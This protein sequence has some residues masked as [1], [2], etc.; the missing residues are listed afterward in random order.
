MLTL[1]LGLSGCHSVRQIPRRARLQQTRLSH[2]S[3]PSCRCW[4]RMHGPSHRVP[5][6]GGGNLIL[7]GAWKRDGVPASL[8]V[9]MLQ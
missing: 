3:P 8:H 5:V 9:G 7:L 2:L 6:K 4:G 1:L